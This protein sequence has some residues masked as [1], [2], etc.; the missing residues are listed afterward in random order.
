MGC[1]R[2]RLAFAPEG[3]NATDREKHCADDLPEAVVV[4]AV[5]IFNDEY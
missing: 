5:A 4:E 3:V 2:A 1:A